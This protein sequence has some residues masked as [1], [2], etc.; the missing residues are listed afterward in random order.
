MQV[1]L[2][3]PED[4]LKAIKLPEEEIQ[5]RLKKELAVRLYSKN[6]LSFGKARQLAGINRWEFHDLLGKEKVIRR[7][8]VH[9]LEDDLKTLEE[10][11]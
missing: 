3:L 6:L 8:D 11:G 1:C 10:L 9:E 7:Y 5:D 4:C 2:E